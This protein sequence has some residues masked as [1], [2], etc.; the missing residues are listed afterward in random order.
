MH[1]TDDERPRALGT[2]PEGLELPTQSCLGPSCSISFLETLL[3][4]DQDQQ[5][6]TRRERAREVTSAPEGVERVSRTATSRTF[7]SLSSLADTWPQQHLGDYLVECYMNLCYP[8]YPFVHGPTLQ[9]CYESIWTAKEPQSNLWIGTINIVYSSGTL[10]TLQA[11]VLTSLYLQSSVNL[12]HS[13]NVIGMAVRQAQSLG[14][15]L[16][17]TYKSSWTLLARETRKRAWWACYLLDSVSGIM[18]GRPQMI[19]D[20]HSTWVEVPSASD[21]D[22]RMHGAKSV[23][24]HSPASLVDLESSESWINV[25]PSEVAFFIATIRLCGLMCEVTKAY[26]RPFDHSRVL[27]IDEKLCEWIA[28][29]V[30]NG[31]SE[32]I[33]SSTNEKFWRQRHVLISRFLNLRI[34]LHRPCVSQDA[35]AAVITPYNSIN[36]MVAARLTSIRMELCVNAAAELIEHISKFYAQGLN[37]ALWYDSNYLFSASIVLLAQMRHKPHKTEH[38]RHLIRLAADVMQRMQHSGKALAGEYLAMM[39]KLKQQVTTQEPSSQARNS[40]QHSAQLVNSA[41]PPGLGLLDGGTAE[42]NAPEAESEAALESMQFHTEDTRRM[43]ANEPLATMA[44]NAIAGKSGAVAQSRVITAFLQQPNVYTPPNLLAHEGV[45]ERSRPRSNRQYRVL[46]NTGPPVSCEAQPAIPSDTAA[47]LERIMRIERDVQDLRTIKYTSLSPSSL[48]DDLS[49]STETEF[50]EEETIDCIHSGHRA[51]NSFAVQIETLKNAASRSTPATARR[52]GLV[53]TASNTS[54]SMSGQSHRTQSGRNSIKTFISSSTRLK[55]LLK[56]FFDEY[57]F[58]YPCI[59]EESFEVQLQCLFEHYSPDQD[60]L[61]LS[62]GDPEM[63]VF[64]AMTCKVLAIAEHIEAD[65]HSSTDAHPPE[66]IVRGEAW[67]RESIRL[68][69]LCSRTADKLMD[70]VRLFMLETLYMLMK[71]NF[72]K[73]SQA[74]CRAVELS[75]SMGLNDESTWASCSGEEARSRRILWWTIYFFD[76]RMAYRLGR[77]YMIRDSEVS[78]ADFTADIRAIESARIRLPV[79]GTATTS[80]DG[81]WIHYLQ[82]N[83]GWGR[84]FAK[85]WDSLYSLASPRAGSIEEIEIMEALLSKLKR[86]LPPEMKWKDPIGSSGTETDVPD[87]MVRMRLVIYTVSIQ[88]H[89]PP[90][91][92][93]LS[94]YQNGDFLSNNPANKT[95]RANLLQ[96]LIRNNLHIRGCEQDC[97]LDAFGSDRRYTIQVCHKLAASTVQAVVS[98]VRTRRRERSFGTYATMCIIESLYYMLSLPST[99]DSIGAFDFEATKTLSLSQAWE[100]LNDLSRRRLTIATNALKVLKGIIESRCS[101]Q[102]SLPE[103]PSTASLNMQNRRLSIDQAFINDETSEHGD[104]DQVTEFHGIDFAMDPDFMLPVLPGPEFD[105]ESLMGTDMGMWD[106]EHMRYT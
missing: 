37:S 25:K 31:S 27:A 88:Y 59:D 84:L 28:K 91:F 70:T 5:Q 56:L 63:L 6:Q 93:Q 85:A 75:F 103:E 71:E 60:C 97:E 50:A 29:F 54:P 32:K 13:W 99:D 65:G 83:V 52:E 10:E 69:G 36:G 90:P 40:G 77:P 35:T 17:K 34:V 98:Y 96:M 57:H 48:S 26:D 45:P 53:G 30:P 89:F 86:T 7:A 61:L 24:P 22:L 55:Y 14:L 23:S 43:T 82:F 106:T 79:A 20:D 92:N 62:D 39:E 33:K 64:A 104:Q 94:F 16:K 81:H 78:V 67:N 38:Y 58:L 21:E 101:S 47:L 74:L 9:K 41:N 3:T 42:G 46:L 73:A 2:Y 18:L 11:L 72:R 100:C 102:L 19:P 12:E 44:P 8:Q 80:L 66:R 49:T 87:R 95:K 15:N 51:Y 68:L 105:G 76:R 1:R 4:Q